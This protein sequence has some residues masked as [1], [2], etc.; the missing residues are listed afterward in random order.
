MAKV[1]GIDLGTTNSVAAVIEA[2]EPVIVENA[3]GAR[4]TPSVVAVNT[5]SGERYVGQVAKRQAVTN[6]ENTLFSIKR[7]MGRKFQDPEVQSSIGKLPYKIVSGNNGDAYVEMGGESYAP[8]QVSSFVLQ[9]I[10]QDAEAKLGEKITQAVITVPAYFNDNQRQATKDAGTIAG[11]EIL[12]IINEPT[13]CSLAYGLDKGKAEA[14]VAVF[15][16]GGGT[17]D[18]TILQMGDGVFEVKSTNGDTFLGGDDFDQ[19]IL[20]WLVQDFRQET[21][22]DLTKDRMALQRLRDAA[23]RAKVELSSV[24]ET[25]INLPFIT[26]D[27]SGPQHLIKQLTRARLEQ[28]VGDLINRTEGPCRQALSDSGFTTESIDDVV[29][30]GGMTRMPAVFEKVKQLFGKEPSRS[31]NPDEAVAIGAAIQAGVLSGEVDDIVLVDV[32]PL[33]LGLET[34]GGVL[35]SLI[36]R[37]TAIPTEKT[38]TFTTAADGQTSVDIHALQGER[39][40]ASDNKSI[41]RFMLDG[42]L[43]A[44]RGTPQIEVKFD[45]NRD[46]ILSVSARDKATGKEQKIVIQSGSGLAKEDIER[47]VDEAR[48]H[49]AEDQQKRTEIETRN[50]ADSLVYTTERMLADN[51]DKVP[52][53][54]KT[55][56]E[57]KV[58]TLKAALAANNMAEIQPAVADLNSAVQRLGQAF[59]S[60]AGD[61]SQPGG[62][63]PFSGTTFDGGPTE[64]GGNA[65]GG[66]ADGGPGDDQQGD[67]TVEGEFREV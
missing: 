55:E 12:R 1:L 46:G 30:V 62:G 19:T 8:P 58:A 56:V 17:F 40:M 57:G 9:K 10:K 60:Q 34:L 36:S 51:A 29:L 54:L 25:E 24:L 11:M 43:P 2:G 65:D 7:L 18:I 61:P 27:A 14:K 53:D 59:Y 64:E 20:D 44:P 28:L 66:S 39:P 41:G 50:Q 21:G 45:I 35:T 31:V 32:T 23:E 63:E 26:A 16:L 37:N 15:D 47:M 48:T 67:D 49:E 3:E 52:A 38:E 13:A 22:I 33:T 4:L 5:R 6:P 42:L